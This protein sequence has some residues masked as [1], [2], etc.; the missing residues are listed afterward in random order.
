M[1]AILKIPVVAVSSAEQAVRD[2]DIVVTSTTSTNPV[3]EGRWLY[4]RHAPQRHRRQ[5]PAKT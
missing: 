1:S 3:V 4:A 2:L 5:F